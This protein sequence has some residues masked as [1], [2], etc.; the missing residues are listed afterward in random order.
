M[1]SINVKDRN[2]ELVQLK[3][4]SLTGD[5]VNPSPYLSIREFAKKYTTWTESSLRWLIYNNTANFN[6]VVVRRV[7][8]SKILLS[9]DSFWH[10][11]ESQ[12]LNKT[13]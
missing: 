13:A 7:G 11:I 4:S 6:D 9:V 8:K 2:N 1:N 3:S 10:W 5:Q 12:N